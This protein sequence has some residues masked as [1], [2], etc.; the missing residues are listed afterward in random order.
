MYTVHTVKTEDIVV[1]ASTI[2]PMC[3]HSAAVLFFCVVVVVVIQIASRAVRK[4]VRFEEFGT[5]CTRT[6]LYKRRFTVLDARI[7]L[8]LRAQGYRISRTRGT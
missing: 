5:A 2:S 7:V 1:A 6:R 8:S 4:I 3:L